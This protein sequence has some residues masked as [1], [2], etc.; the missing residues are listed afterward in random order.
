[1]TTTTTSDSA[2]GLDNRHPAARRTAG[3]HHVVEGRS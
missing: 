3:A 2:T 1:M